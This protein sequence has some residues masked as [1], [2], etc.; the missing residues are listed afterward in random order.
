VL[1]LARLARMLERACTELTLAQYRLLALIAEGEDRASTLAGKLALAKP[2]VS[3]TVETLVERGYLARE[4]VDGDRRAIRLAV[5][6]AGHAALDTAQQAMEDRL[7]VVLGLV[8][9]Q[10]LVKE[11]LD[12]LHLGLDALRTERRR[13]RR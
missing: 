1:T 5:T 8:P 3:A 9:D 12:Q 7:A 6:A 2:T 4:A 13:S 11:A 10:G